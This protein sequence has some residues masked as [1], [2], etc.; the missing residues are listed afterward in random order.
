MDEQRYSQRVRTALLVVAVV[1]L[2]VGII[3]FPEFA[4]FVMPMVPR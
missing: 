3:A 4:A 1:A 2:L